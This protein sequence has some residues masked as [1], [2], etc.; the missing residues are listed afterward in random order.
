VKVGCSGALTHVELQLISYQGQIAA[1][2]GTYRFWLTPELDARA[3]GDPDRTF[4]IYMAAYAGLALR[5]VPGP[6]SEQDARRFAQA[7]LDPRSAAG[8]PDARG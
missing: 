7:G 3:A 5:G 8:Q 1:A 4:V 2:A 6:Y